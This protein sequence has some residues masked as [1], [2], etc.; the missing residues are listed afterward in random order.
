MRPDR[1]RPPARP[2]R[3]PR[4]GAGVRLGLLFPGQ[5]CLHEDMLPWLDDAPAA[6]PLLA[7]MQAVLG[8]ADWRGRMIA[9]PGWAT[10]NA[11]AQALVV[12]ASLAAWAVLAPHLPAPAAVAG[13]SVGELAAFSAAGSL[14][15]AAAVRLTR[16]RA[17]LMD[18]CEPAGPDAARSGLLSVNGLG[19]TALQALC[20]R[21]GLEVAIRIAPDR[22]VVGGPRPALEAAQAA[23]LDA[24]AACQRLPVALASHTGVLAPAV[25]PLRAAIADLG[26]RAPATAL[27]CNLTGGPLRR[28]D[29]LCDALAGQVAATVAW[30]DCMDSLAERG[31]DCVL[32]VGPGTALSRLWHQRHPAIP[33]R[34]LQ[35]F[36]SWQGARAWVERQGL[37]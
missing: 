29:E 35:E 2:G 7:E 32:E 12:G 19:P 1:R 4:Q 31:I 18:A 15:A 11:A 10:G 27:M 25:A 30:D 16:I 13:Y 37:R 36:G 28:P 22:A 14:G 3:L 34:A 8:T 21:F 24:G 9:E 6:A 20:A 26:L 23:A 17:A 5:G 33:A